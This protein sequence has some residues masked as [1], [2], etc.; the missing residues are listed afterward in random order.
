MSSSN[1]SSQP[2]RHVSLNVYDF[3]SEENN[4]TFDWLVFEKKLWQNLS[5]FQ[6]I[7][8]SILLSKKKKNKENVSTKRETEYGT[9]ELRQMRTGSCLNSKPE[10]NEFFMTIISQIG[11]WM[12][13]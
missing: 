10:Q 2:Q 9:H 1:P 4:R 7:P 11:L 5:E 12:S 13:L 6:G 3:P 8:F